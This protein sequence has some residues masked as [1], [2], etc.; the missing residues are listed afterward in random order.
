MF[1]GGYINELFLCDI[2]DLE[3]PLGFEMR[4]DAFG[5]NVTYESV[6]EATTTATLGMSQT[7]IARGQTRL[8]GLENSELTSAAGR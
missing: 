5:L 3:L 8:G 7:S 4:A 1:I 2:D 6:E